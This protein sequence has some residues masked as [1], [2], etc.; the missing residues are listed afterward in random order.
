MSPAGG[1]I[2][3]VEGEKALNPSGAPVWR[4]RREYLLIDPWPRA[5]LRGHARHWA[6]RARLKFAAIRDHDL[7]KEI[8]LN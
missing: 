3:V 2:R 5:L 7:G 1:V 6:L 4:A 8:S